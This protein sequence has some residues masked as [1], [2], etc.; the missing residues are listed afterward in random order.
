MNILLPPKYIAFSENNSFYDLCQP[1]FASTDIKDVVFYRMYKDGSHFHLI[2]N[3]R[4]NKY[5]LIDTSGRYISDYRILNA[6]YAHNA[7]S[8][9]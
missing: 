8:R 6:L 2:T 9:N 7:F 5:M 3:D 4:L 1:L